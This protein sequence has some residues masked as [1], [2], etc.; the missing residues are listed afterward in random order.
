VSWVK[1][2]NS[3]P[4]T[5]TPPLFSVLPPASGRQNGK[6]RVICFDILAV[7]LFHQPGKP[8]GV[9]GP[10]KPHGIAAVHVIPVAPGRPD[11]RA[12]PAPCGEAA[13]VQGVQSMSTE[14]EYKDVSTHD[15]Q[16]VRFPCSALAP[17]RGRATDGTIHPGI[18]IR[19][20]APPWASIYSPP[21]VR[22]DA[23]V[24][25]HR[26]F[27]DGVKLVPFRPGPVLLRQKHFEFLARMNL[28]M[29]DLSR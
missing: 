13:L 11:L 8:A 17:G 5:V 15:S 25:G 18:C 2:L 23:S 26:P 14:R 16:Y 28:G 24:S 3:Q 1:E 29:S 20:R 27:S 19:V 22:R 4:N 9:N 21:D 12:C 7:K 10:D 6:R